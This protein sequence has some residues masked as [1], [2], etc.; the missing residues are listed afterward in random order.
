MP[1]MIKNVPYKPVSFTGTDKGQR[2]RPSPPKKMPEKPV[3]EE[4]P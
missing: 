4:L 2:R 3:E 1:M